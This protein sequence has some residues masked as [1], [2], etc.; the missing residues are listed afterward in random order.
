[1]ILD[2]LYMYNHGYKTLSRKLAILY[3]I[4][5]SRSGIDAQE[6]SL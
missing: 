3:T 1:M 2:F 4:P 6:A 5:F